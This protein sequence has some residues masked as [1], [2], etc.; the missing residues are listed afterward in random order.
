MSNK[1]VRQITLSN[2]AVLCQTVKIQNCLAFNEVAAA[3]IAIGMYSK[4][5]KNAQPAL[6]AVQLA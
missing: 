5:W 6:D 3:A 2:S 1:N 4:V